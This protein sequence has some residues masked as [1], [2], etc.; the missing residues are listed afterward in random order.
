MALTGK[1]WWWACDFR[2]EPTNP[3]SRMPK[4]SLGDE[5][6]S[7]NTGFVVTS[8]EFRLMKNFAVHSEAYCRKRLG[9]IVLYFIACEATPNIACTRR[10]PLDKDVLLFWGY[11]LSY[12]PL[13]LKGFG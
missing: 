3:S 7:T 1:S 10:G 12:T 6:F 4:P 2:V 11:C 13:P 9:L 5:V 8:W